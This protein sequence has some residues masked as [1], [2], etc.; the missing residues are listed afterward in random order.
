MMVKKIFKM[1][2]DNFSQSDWQSFLSLSLILV[3]ML[4]ALI[5]RGAN[6]PKILR[7][8]AIWALILFV[9]VSLYAYRDKFSDFS[10]RLAGEMNPSSAR[11]TRDGDLVIN[12]SQDGHYYI[13]TKINGTSIRFMIDTGATD[14]VI[15]AATAKKIGIN[16]NNLNF[17]KPYQTANGMIWG[18]LT[19][20]KKLEVGDIELENVAISVSKADLGTSLL[21]MSFLKRF[22]KYEFYQDRLIL[23]KNA[24]HF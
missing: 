15:S 21:G 10:N 23:S 8:L 2:F 18:A 4:G 11:I 20:V 13:D 1:S 6:F 7:H 12:I 14:V 5:S 17:N 19:T 9:I 24:S 22:K 3:A 16:I